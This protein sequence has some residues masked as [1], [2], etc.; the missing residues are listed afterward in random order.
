VDPAE[1]DPIR[2]LTERNREVLRLW[3]E[4]KEAKEIARLF[5]V[6]H[7]AINEHLRTSRRALNVATSK[8]AAA[9]LVEFERTG[10]Y[11]GLVYKPQG[12][13]VDHSPAMIGGSKDEAEQQPLAGRRDAVREEQMS[14]RARGLS[15]LRWKLP[16]DPEGRLDHELTPGE[17]LLWIALLALSILAALQTAFWIISATAQGIVKLGDRIGRY[18]L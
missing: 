8:E 7:H 11:K 18:F 6:T 12:V 4:G 10:T 1:P 14:Y 5:N 9:I 16:F 2:R 13:A 3:Y 15:R 17:K